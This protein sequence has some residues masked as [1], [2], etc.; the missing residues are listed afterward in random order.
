MRTI[1]SAVIF[2]VTAVLLC[3]CSSLSGPVEL[4]D[5]ASGK[6][7]ELKCGERMTLVLESNPTTGYLWRFSAP[8]DEQ[9]LVL[10]GDTYV[11]PASELMGAPGKRRL[12]FEAVNPG[13]TGIRLEYK[14]PWEQNAKPEKTFQLMIYVTGEPKTNEFFGE[15]KDEETP[16]VSSKGQ[17]VPYKKKG[18]F[19]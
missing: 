4:T 19:D 10:C 17:V 14:R 2:C 6:T 7:V 16:R 11:S 1:F 8:Y 15:K 13:R 12:T 18:L 3:G 9:V 5:Q